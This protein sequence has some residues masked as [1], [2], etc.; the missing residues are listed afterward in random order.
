MAFNLNFSNANESMARMQNF[1]QMNL[2]NKI[3][4]QRMTDQIMLE[5]QLSRDRMAQSLKNQQEMEAYRS[6]MTLEEAKNSAVLRMSEQPHFTSLI[7]KANLRNTPVYQDPRYK[8]M[9]DSA[10]SEIGQWTDLITHSI[11]LAHE[12]KMTNE[13]VGNM[14]KGGDLAA[15]L[16]IMTE[17]G[18]QT[19]A[20]GTEGRA[21]QTLNWE[22]TKFGIENWKGAIDKTM[23]YLNG[24]GVKTPDPL[25]AKNVMNMF[26]SSGRV[27]NPLSPETQGTVLSELSKMRSQVLNGKLPDEGQQNFLSQAM[28]AYGIEGGKPPGPGGKAPA[29]T[30]VPSPTSGVAQSGQDQ[31]QQVVKQNF[32]STYRERFLRKV[33][34]EY[35]DPNAVLDSTSKSTMERMADQA[36]SQYWDSLQGTSN[37][38]TTGTPQQTPI[39]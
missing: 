25:I 30:Q 20:S 29:G 15:A 26:A 16:K 1:L 5:D 10:V 7:Q 23:E 14:L 4:H 37:Q 6:G 34:P 12:G 8:P 24:Q 38:P 11:L 27:P 35:Y 33:Y 2:L 28:N 3:S 17:A 19:R 21:A 36:A 39:K 32:L 13:S 22:K 18:E 31:A 9:I